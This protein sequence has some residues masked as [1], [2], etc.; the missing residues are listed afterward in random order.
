MAP[1]GRLRKMP[2]VCDPFFLPNKRI[3]KL[4]LNTNLELCRS[5]VLTLVKLCMYHVFKPYISDSRYLVYI[6]CSYLGI[7]AI[8]LWTDLP[9]YGGLPNFRKF[10]ILV[11]SLKKE[12]F[13]FVVNKM[14]PINHVEGEV[15]LPARSVKYVHTI[16][17]LIPQINEIFHSS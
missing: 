4:K 15:V 8:F 6:F 14:V 16:I 9:F 17:Q 3:Y 2:C 11:D 13:G 5:R 12:I 7:L 10:Q 1:F